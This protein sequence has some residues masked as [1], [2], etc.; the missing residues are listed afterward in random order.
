[1]TRNIDGQLGRPT[2]H[3]PRPAMP[4]LRLVGPARPDRHG[5][6]VPRAA[7]TAQARPNTTRAVP[8]RPE[9]TMAHRASS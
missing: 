7:Y 2:Q 4:R 8:G 1:M 3:G 6:A 9:G 5:R